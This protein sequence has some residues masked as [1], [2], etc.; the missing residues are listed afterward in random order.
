MVAIVARPVDRAEIV[1]AGE[2]AAG[3][4][5]RIENRHRHRMTVGTGGHVA[6]HGPFRRE[7]AHPLLD[8]VAFAPVQHDE[9]TVLVDRIGNHPGD[10]QLV[11]LLS[12]IVQQVRTHRIGR[13]PPVKSQLLLEYGDTLQQAFVFAPQGKIGANVCEDAVHPANHLVRAGEQLGLRIIRR[14]RIIP[15]GDRFEYDEQDRHVDSAQEFDQF[16]H[17]SRESFRSFVISSGTRN[18]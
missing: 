3:I 16:I 1:V 2:L 8:A 15:D 18:G 7:H 13:R 4:E 14:V 17:G 11:G 6:D 5:R 12:H 9:V 10:G